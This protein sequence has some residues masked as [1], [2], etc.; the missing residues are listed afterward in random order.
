MPAP[1]SGRATSPTTTSRSMPN[2]GRDRKQS[3]PSYEA[4]LRRFDALLDR[5]DA[6]LPAP[7]VATDWDAGIAFRWRRLNGTALLQPVARPH[8]IRL[9]DLR[10]IERQKELVE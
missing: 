3:A 4:L 2:T 10:G 1:R 5:I 6:V 7:P 8:D 9:A